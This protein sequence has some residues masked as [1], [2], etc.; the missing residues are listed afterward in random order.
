MKR[1]RRGLVL[2][3]RILRLLLTEWGN[4]VLLEQI[5]D[6]GENRNECCRARE[7]DAIDVSSRIQATGIWKTLNQSSVAGIYDSLEFGQGSDS[8]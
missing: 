5:A 3:S 1:N 8:A 4:T 6:L 7:R 2:S